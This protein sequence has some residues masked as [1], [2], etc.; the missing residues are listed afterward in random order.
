M[1]IRYII[2]LLLIFILLPVKLSAVELK[3]IIINGND[4]IADETIQMF[5]SVSIN[6]EISADNIN[7]ILKSIY[8]SSFFKEV[9]VNLENNILTINVVE[10]PLI[11]KIIF[12]GIKAKKIKE[13]IAQNLN[14]KS[15]SSFN[16]VY[17]QKDKS[18]IQSNLKELG[19]YFSKIETRINQLDNNKVDIFYEISLGKKAKIKKISFIG[20]KIFKDKKLKSLIVS[21]EYKFWKF[22]SGKKF[23][24]ESVINLDKRLLKNF[25]LNKGYI[26]VDVNS[27][28]AKLIDESSFELIF[29][30]RANKKVFFNNLSLELPN[31]FNKENYVSIS[32][33]FEDLNGKPYSINKIE[34]ILDE[35][36]KISV[37]DQYES[38]KSSVVENIENDKLNLKFIIQG[39]D[40]IYIQKINIFGNNITREDVIRNQ[41]E[42]D[43]G[44]PFNDI[45]LTKTINNLK[46]LNFFKNVYEEVIDSD[47]TNEKIINISIEEKPTGEISAGA[48]V[49]TSG[50]T[51]AF[52]VKEKN[53]LGKGITVLA[54][55]TINEESLKGIFSVSN[56]NFNN[57]DKSINFSAEAI[58]T[59]RLSTSGYKTN[60][61]G[62]SLGTK[63]E[64]QDDFF[65]GLGFSNFYESIETDSTASSRQRALDG[66]YWDSSFNIN[67]DYDKRNQKFQATDGFRSRYFV[68]MPIISETYALSNTFDF[69]SYSEL[70]E[71]NVSILSFYLRSSNS[72]NDEN[73]KLSER[74]F[75]P[76]DKLRGFERGKI[77]PKDG[78]DFVGGNYAAAFNF[79]STIPQIFENSQNFDFLFFIDVANVWGVDYFKGDDEGSKIRSSIGI[80]LDWLT[81]IGPLNF[82]LAESLSKSS[83]DITESFRFNLGTTF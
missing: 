9:S 38:I 62:F 59:D 46:N 33:I 14:L 53:Y 47:A 61:S 49:G 78:D 21:E 69:K 60:K 68:N 30:I 55:A 26:N 63:F 36:D 40:K 74:I 16:E 48:G 15:R 10:N 41:F 4:R 79:S 24:N 77:G 42:I 75:L 11:Q 39:T 27:S 66:N 37:S 35:I 81:P 44:D 64:Y 28:F 57:T 65:L 83:S 5:A 82:T 71:N 50:G 32:S 73:I 13:K 3:Q 43:E 56:P 29:N 7:N 52:G 8:D 20:D 34:K 72:L 17:L 31:D 23:L 18:I 22:I 1:F 58:E 19:Y 12:N 67:F 2:Y 45:L 76:S 54:N 25:Y 51:I 70:Y 80:G 6:E